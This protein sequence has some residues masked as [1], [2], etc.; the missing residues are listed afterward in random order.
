MW[1]FL[2]SGSR[3]IGNRIASKHIKVAQQVAKKYGIELPDPD[4]AYLVEGTEEFD[5]CI[6]E[7]GWAQHFA[8]LNREEMVDRVI[9]Q[10]GEWVGG[11]V[12]ELERI[13][14]HHNFTGEPHP[15]RQVGVALPEGCHSSPRR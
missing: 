14:C 12:Q 3:G 8:L 15:L 10:F 7:L 1:L 9:R 11:E 5:A 6:R 4:L 2:H 13:N